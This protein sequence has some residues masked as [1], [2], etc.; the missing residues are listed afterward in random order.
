[1][2]E[3]VDVAVSVQ[4]DWYD[5]TAA[6]KHMNWCYT[7]IRTYVKEIDKL[8]TLD[9]EHRRAVK[10]CETRLQSVQADL[11]SKRRSTHKYKCALVSAKEELDRHRGLEDA[12][13]KQS[14]KQKD[15]SAALELRV[16]KL[17]HA[18]L[19][20]RTQRA[21]GRLVS[22]IAKL[23]K[24][25][26]GKRLAAAVHPDKA[27]AECSDLATELFKFVQGARESSSS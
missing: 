14:E 4:T 21:G 10:M 15:H 1:M 19:D 6:R 16:R 7:T 27:P 23:A 12:L 3:K 26:I 20:A 17:E 11:E 13:R 18:L 9:E 22:A 25:P 24:G 5:S 2:S 8:R